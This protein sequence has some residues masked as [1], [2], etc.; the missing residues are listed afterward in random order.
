M[1][2]IWN[3]LDKN[4]FKIFFLTLL[5]FTPW[6]S[7][8]YIEGHDTA[9]HVA[10]IYGLIDSIDTI[11]K[12]KILPGIANNFGYGSPIFYPQFTHIVAA[13]FA[14]G[15]SLFSLNVLYSLKITHFL[16][17]YFSGVF[18]Y[19]LI[20]EVSH[21]KKIA[22]LAAFFYMTFPYHLADIFVRDALAE[23]FVF[24]FLPLV[25]LGLHYLFQDNKKKFYLCFTIGYLGLI[26]S[27]LVMTVYTTIFIIVCFLFN[28][29][30][31]FKRDRILA[32]CISSFFILILS[33]PFLIPLLEHKFFGN[34]VV[35]L[36]N[37]VVN[38]YSIS[39]EALSFFDLFLLKP[40]ESTNIM[41]FLNIF[42][43]YLAIIS[44]L[45]YKKISNEKNKWIIQSAIIFTVLGMLM[46]NEFFPWKKIPS[47][48]LLLQFPWRLETFISFGISILAAF[49]FLTFNKEDKKIRSFL[50]IVISG[51]YI[52]FVLSNVNYFKVN[53][54]NYDLNSLGMGYQ[55][56]YLPV[57]TLE[58]ITYFSNRSQDV[59][60]KHGEGKIKVLENKV[61]YLLFETYD[62]QTP[63]TLE[64]PRL[65]YFGYSISFKDSNGKVSKIKYEENENGFIQIVVDGNYRVEVKYTGTKLDQIANYLFMI[66]LI[67]L[68]GF[69]CYFGIK[70]LQKSQKM[71]K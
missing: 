44:I 55:K 15:L 18:M 56:E 40:N 45:K 24:T 29:K 63:L 9:Y 62:V 58:N 2:K 28:L 26:H 51:F 65:F 32:L 68:G 10:N 53:L 21:D 54:Q 60:I 69:A 41:F 5:L 1:K 38:G 20:K 11:F 27:H 23:V 66:T 36:P 46:I 35:F 43:V 17:M 16:S 31:V 37:Y 64:L 52:L 22:L 25:L 57:N 30:K 47:I 59:L 61:P 14:Q 7:R 13:L 19:K 50:S 34:Y 67:F 12:A 71:I 6:I 33:M 3:N 4:Y 8:Y 39:Q 48:L 70:K 49:S 42:V